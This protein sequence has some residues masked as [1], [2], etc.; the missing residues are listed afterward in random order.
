MYGRERVGRYK[1]KSLVL[2]DIKRTFVLYIFALE[3]TFRNINMTHEVLGHT[4]SFDSE[5]CSQ[6]DAS[7]NTSS[8]FSHLQPR[9]ANFPFL[10]WFMS[11]WGT[12]SFL[13]L[14]S[15]TGYT[16]GLAIFF[17]ND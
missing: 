8:E 9:A 17:R 13:G 6:F 16:T 12:Q 1:F 14:F 10:T 5:V 4:E 2:V 15:I 3:Y 11:L 7:G